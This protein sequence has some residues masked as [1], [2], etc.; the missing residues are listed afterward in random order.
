[1]LTRVF[2]SFGANIGNPIDQIHS[3]LGCLQKL[4]DI[5]NFKCSSLYLTPPMGPTQPDYING[6]VEFNFSQSATQ[7]LTQL[8]A[9]E[10]QHGRDRQNE[11][12]WG[13]RPLD[14]D[15]LLFGDNTINLHQLKIP[16]P[17]LLERA[18]VIIPLA[19]L[20]PQ[21][22]LPNGKNAAEHAL[23]LQDPLIRRQDNWEN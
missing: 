7:L 20:A 6:V 9:I 16:H 1:M 18:F 2:V 13:P 19:E 22:I 10:R 4:P 11:T 8:Q 5:S 14:L 15:I 3:G 23:T 21:L 12:R 17:G